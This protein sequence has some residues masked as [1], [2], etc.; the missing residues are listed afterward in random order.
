MATAI[1]A[2]KYP[3]QM[4]AATQSP[5]FMFP[6]YVKWTSQCATAVSTQEPDA[7]ML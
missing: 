3:S 7:L 4:L 6:A 1:L 5:A 2:D